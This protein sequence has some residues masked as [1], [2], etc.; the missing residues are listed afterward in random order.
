MSLV[1]I[2]NSQPDV[3]ALVE[4]TLAADPDRGF[5]L[6]SARSA[7][8]AVEILSFDLPE[9]IL[10]NA[11]DPSFDPAPLLDSLQ[12]DSWMHNFG[13]VAFYDPKVA[14]E[15][16]ATERL[17]GVNV[18][19]FLPLGALEAHLLK[20]LRIL[21]ANRQILVRLE[22]A[23]KG[24]AKSTGS[25]NIEN[26]PAVVPVYAGLA[27]QS[28]V[29]RGLIPA[30]RK[31]DLQIALVELVQN[32]IEHGHC[33]VTSKEKNAHLAK[34][35]GMAELIRSKVE[36]DPS[37]ALKKVTL[38]WE[39]QPAGSRFFVR[40]QG[41]GFDV[42]AY[43]EK[44]RTHQLDELSGRGIKLA[45]GIGGKLSY[46][47]QGNVACLQLVHEGIAERRTPRGFEADEVVVAQK[48]DIIFQQDELS[49]HIFYITSGQYGVYHEGVPVG[50]LTPAD[51][52]MGEMSFLM[53]NRRTA[54]VVC[55]TP[56]RLVKISR[57]SFVRTLRQFPQYGLFL[58]KLM[59]RKLSL[60]NQ[61]RSHKVIS[62]M[63]GE[64]DLSVIP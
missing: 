57:R 46:N 39:I 45:R 17:H 16:E 6:T 1:A 10:W 32:G 64:D 34:G 33:G 21:D 11:T 59:A 22:L 13:I 44:M 50:L 8:E 52:F 31:R 54:T 58:A 51:V 24:A 53:N 61:E 42:M 2:L 18:L 55:E 23:E 28:L 49:D 5:V 9:I 27:A 48:G 35:G 38:E 4:Q 7:E 60:G 30:S 37:L 20:H 14:N 3:Q 62:A 26:D 63:E 19:T 56:G 36:A 43:R 41:P 15:V 12:N 25:F 47:K 40:D 29:L